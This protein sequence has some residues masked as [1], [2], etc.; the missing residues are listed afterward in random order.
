MKF[1]ILVNS[2]SSMVAVD[3]VEIPQETLEW[4]SAND[5]PLEVQSGQSALF[6]SPR[7]SET[8]ARLLSDLAHTGDNSEGLVAA[9][10]L[11]ALLAKVDFHHG[12]V[13]E[14]LRG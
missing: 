8:L 14:F 13:V 10:D 1:N 4:L 9:R 2:G 11:A 7:L 3:S 12:A 5:Y 6:V